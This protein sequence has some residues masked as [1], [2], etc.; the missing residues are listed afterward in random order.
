MGWERIKGWRSASSELV[1]RVSVMADYVCPSHSADILPAFKVRHWQ[2]MGIFPSKGERK[3]DLRD[4][5]REC[6][7]INRLNQE[8]IKSRESIYKIEF[9]SR[10][11][12]AHST[13]KN[14][15]S[16]P[17]ANQIMI[18]PKRE[19]LM[20]SQIMIYHIG[21]VHNSAWLQHFI[22]CSGFWYLLLNP[23]FS[24]STRQ[25]TP[26]HTDSYQEALR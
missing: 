7:K 1:S 18:Y 25:P 26:P 15:H 21:C 2:M 24:P 8:L 14:L 20:D 22:K 5:S 23:Y 9:A 3:G 13:P 11:Q 16:P 10:L 17:H 19:Y 12:C 4:G 6:C